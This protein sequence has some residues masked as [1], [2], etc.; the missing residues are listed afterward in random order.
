ML[1]QRTADNPERGSRCPWQDAH[2]TAHGILGD[3]KNEVDRIAA[4][5]HKQ[6]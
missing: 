2:S 3:V 5:L 4:L 6:P 1:G